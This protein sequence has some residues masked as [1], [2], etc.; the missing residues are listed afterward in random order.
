[1]AS[2]VHKYSAYEAAASFF[3]HLIVK[4]MMYLV[5]NQPQN[6]QIVMTEKKNHVFLA[7]K[8]IKHKETTSRHVSKVTFF[9][10]F[11]GTLSPLMLALYSEQIKLWPSQYSFEI[12]SHYNIFLQFFFS[13]FISL[14]ESSNAVMVCGGD[15]INGPWW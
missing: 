3:Q 6:L 8:L 11:P 12:L 14:Q 13:F 10:G 2:G 5:M 1:M 15:N 7:W 9:V 4:V